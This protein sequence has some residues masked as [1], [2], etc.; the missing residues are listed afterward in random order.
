MQADLR[1]SW[2]P[3]IIADA[4]KSSRNPNLHTFVVVGGSFAVAGAFRLI[5]LSDPSTSTKNSSGFSAEVSLRSV[6]TAAASFEA[7]GVNLGETTG[8]RGRAV[9]LIRTTQEQSVHSENSR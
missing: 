1:N 2:L 9:T 5:F 4:S 3:E 6:E 8:V 7:I